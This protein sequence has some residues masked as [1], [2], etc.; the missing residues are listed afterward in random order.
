MLSG[1]AQKP[2][3]QLL[4]MIKRDRSKTMSMGFIYTDEA[5]TRVCIN[6]FIYTCMFNSMHSLVYAHKHKQT[7]QSGKLEFTC[8]NSSLKMNLT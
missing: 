5:D 1:M 8:K 7:Q 6:M 2:Q 3:K 4:N